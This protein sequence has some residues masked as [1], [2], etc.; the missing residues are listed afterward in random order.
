MIYLYNNR[1][2]DVHDLRTCMPAAKGLEGGGGKG[3]NCIPRSFLNFFSSIIRTI[4]LRRMR[5]ARQQGM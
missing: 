2:N 5:E 3:A 4:R 1:P